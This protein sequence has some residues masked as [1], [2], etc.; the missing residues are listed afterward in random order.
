MKKMMLAIV[1]LAIAGGSYAQTGY[2]MTGTIEGVNEGNIYLIRA[3]KQG[4]LDTLARTTVQQG[5]FEFSGVVEESDFTRVYLEG[6]YRTVTFFLENV[7]YTAKIDLKGASRIEGGYEQSVLNEFQEISAR[8]GARKG[9]FMKEITRVET[10]EQADSLEE[11]RGLMKIDRA[12]Q[13][14]EDHVITFNPNSCVS[15]SV[16]Q[17]GM[18]MYVIEF[19]KKRYSM[20]SEKGKA[21]RWGK[22]VGEYIAQRERTGV[23]AIAPDFTLTDLKGKSFNMSD[24]KGKVKVLVFWQPDYENS[25]KANIMLEEL[26]QEYHDKGLEIVNVIRGG[27]RKAIS[28]IVKE[29]KLTYKQGIV[30]GDDLDSML[31]LYGASILV[32]WPLFVLD[33]NNKI[34]YKSY[35]LKDL[36]NDMPKFFK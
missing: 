33:S 2:K 34:M 19:T 22:S 23:G 29:D 31:K 1:A 36:K 24:V 14:E 9:A 6:N 28:K 30:A 10:K 27:D 26:Y 4:G 32:D 25:R 3:A 13:V 18:N 20:L 11:A 5:K 16:V 12:A 21:T 35:Y 8:A 15:A 7:D 17:S